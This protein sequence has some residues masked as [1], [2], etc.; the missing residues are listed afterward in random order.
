MKLVGEPDKELK[1]RNQYYL[2]LFYPEEIEESNLP[3]D[4]L[5]EP[6]C[7]SLRTKENRLFVKSPNAG[8][9]IKYL[10]GYKSSYERGGVIKFERH[11]KNPSSCIGSSIK[12]CLKK[13]NLNYLYPVFHKGLVY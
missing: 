5:L 1:S 7:S 4:L 13:T 11:G 9:G 2:Y 12:E 10:F 6:Y 3:I 8:G